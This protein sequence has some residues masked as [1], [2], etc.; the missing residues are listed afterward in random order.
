M[1]SVETAGYLSPSF[2][3]IEKKHRDYNAVPRFMDNSAAAGADNELTPLKT[4][5]NEDIQDFPMTLIDIERA[6]SAELKRVLESYGLPTVGTM[7]ARKR[8]LKNYLGVT[9]AGV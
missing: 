4:Q 3:L 8:Q 7:A 9:K 1:I 6:N 2:L 5:R